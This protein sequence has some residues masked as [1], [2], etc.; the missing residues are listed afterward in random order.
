MVLIIFHLLNLEYLAQHKISQ[1]IE[2]Q[3]PKYKTE[4]VKSS[5]AEQSTT[6]IDDYIIDF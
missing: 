5:E 2:F 1:K 4:G 6:K 3:P